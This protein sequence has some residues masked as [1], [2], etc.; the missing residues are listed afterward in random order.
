MEHGFDHDLAVI[1][2]GRI[3]LPWAAVLAAHAGFSVTCVDVDEDRIDEINAG[4]APFAEPGLHEALAEG[5]RTERL[6]ATTDASVV[7]DHRYVAMTI[8]AR[9]DKM[10]S[11][12]QVVR[13]YAEHLTGSQILINRTTLPVRTISRMQE[14]V[15]DVAS[16]PPGFAVLPERLAEG[17]AVEE[18]LSLPNI[19]GTN[20]QRTATA[21]RAL[22]E[23]LGTEV[24]FTDPRTAM[25]VKLIDNSY[26]D[27]L[28]AISNQIAYVA[29]VLEL[30]GHEAIALANADYPRNDI[31]SPG[32]VGGKCLPKDPHFLMDET[33]C[34]QP[35]TPDL[36]NATRRTN[37]SLPSYIAT[38]ILTKRPEKVAVLG[39][40]YKGGVGDTYNSPAASI[41]EIIDA[42]GVSVSAYDPFVDGLDDTLENALHGADVVVLATPHA[43]FSDAV[44]QINEHAPSTAVMYD[45]WGF[46]D[47]ERLDIEYDGFGIE[48]DTA[49]AEPEAG[50]F[51]EL[52]Q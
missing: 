27:A 34:D 10:D 36:F 48:R 16:E 46:F 26:R 11:F 43:E 39:L 12:V 35:T 21:M 28:F 13:E 20:D 51:T 49:V 29:D 2:A 44:E 14:I 23:P 1:G 32:L 30:D 45:V 4:D 24:Q 19:V 41:A 6:R 40:S 47:G 7:E 9:R 8:N 50:V 5:L 3:G 33:I 31:P 18:I 42:Q 15:G 37:A 38:E 25:F 52:S 17:K 22:L